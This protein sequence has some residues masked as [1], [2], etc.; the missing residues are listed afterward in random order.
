MPLFDLSF[1]TGLSVDCELL[2]GELGGNL[3]KIIGVS[4]GIDFKP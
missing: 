2:K 3:G 4:L 1:C